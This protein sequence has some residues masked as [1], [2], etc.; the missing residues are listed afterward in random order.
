MFLLN[1]LGYFADGVITTGRVLSGLKGFYLDI[2]GKFLSR[3]LV[4]LL[5]IGVV[6]L[7]FNAV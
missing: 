6:V 7:V 5:A 3:V 1:N 2:C 4:L